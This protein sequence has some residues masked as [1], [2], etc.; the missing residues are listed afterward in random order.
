[1]T[2]LG[3]ERMSFLYENLDQGNAIVLNAGVAFSF[4]RFH[5]L[6]GDMVRG[7]WLRYVRRFNSALLGTATDLQEFLFGGE[8]ESLKAFIP[9]LNEVQRDACFYCGGR[10]KGEAVDVDHFIPWSRYPVDLGHN[11]VLAHARPCNARKSGRLASV[12]HLN[13]W[14]TR[15]AEHG[16]LMGAQFDQKEIIHDLPTS[17]KVATWAYSQLESAG[18]LTWRQGEEMVILDSR[19][20]QLLGN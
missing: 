4:R 13:A 6:V 16:D 9:I 14:V 11:F 2:T 3:I 5:G 20:R 18:G 10:M 1:M 19:W 17:F 15:N 12:E 8:R 7:A